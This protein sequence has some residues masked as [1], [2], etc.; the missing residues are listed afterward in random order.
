[1]RI[2]KKKGIYFPLAFTNVQT[3]TII[4]NKH[5]QIII[6]PLKKIFIGDDMFTS[7]SIFFKPI[8]EFKSIKMTWKLVSKTYKEEG[9]LILNI[10]PDII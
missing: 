2:M 3:S 4:D 10:E 7:R 1:M 8:S 6:E 5:N 9:F